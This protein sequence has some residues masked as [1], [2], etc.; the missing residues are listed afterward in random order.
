MIDPAN[1]ACRDIVELL[2]DYLDGA[3]DDETARVVEA[4]LA[5]CEGCGRALEQL[6]ETIRV[7]GMLGEEQLTPEQRT[8]LLEAF[9]GWVAL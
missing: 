6:R 1:P 3:L 4:H 5:D 8:T 9:R 2:S 7:T